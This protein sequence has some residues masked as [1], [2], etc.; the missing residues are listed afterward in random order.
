MRRV[1][2]SRLAAAAAGLF[3]LLSLAAARVLLD[4]DGER[5][6]LAGRVVA[7]VCAFRLHTGKP[8]PNCGLTRSLALAA[9]GRLPEAL[10]ANPT[11]PAALAGTL[12]AAGILLWLALAS[13]PGAA[14]PAAAAAAGIGALVAALWLAHWVRAWTS[15]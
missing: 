2:A 5:V 3:L 15:M 4:I 14:R 9:R 12:L 8:C 6:L 10:D 13:R 7:P 11:G 1:E